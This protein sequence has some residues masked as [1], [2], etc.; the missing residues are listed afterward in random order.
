MIILLSVTV[1]G[2]V[3]TLTNLRAKRDNDKAI[4]IRHRIHGGSEVYDTP[5]KLYHRIKQTPTHSTTA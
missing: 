2:D 5:E 1:M 4:P 3:L